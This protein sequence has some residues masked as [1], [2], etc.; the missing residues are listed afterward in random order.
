MK[1]KIKALFW[2]VAVLIIFILTLNSCA[3]FDRCSVKFANRLKVT[4]S[5]RVT[6]PVSVLVPRD[7]VV[8]SFVT[9][10]TYLYKEIHQ[11]RAKV[12]I[13]RTNTITTVQARCDTV[14]VTKFIRVKVPGERVVWGVK[15]WYKTAF[16]VS[17]C[18]L[19]LIVGAAFIYFSNRHDELR[20]NQN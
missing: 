11:G 3:T 4:D 17:M 1:A 10:T 2:P 20:I 15:P 14:T 6:V 12:I 18:L 16:N 13:E 5:V 7:S 8:T 19:F 9:D